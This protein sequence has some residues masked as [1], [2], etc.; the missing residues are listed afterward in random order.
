MTL[1]IPSSRVMEQLGAH[2]ACACKSGLLI[3]L[4][5]DL[6]AGKT[7]LA[8]GFIRALGYEGPVKSPTYTLVEPYTLARLPV[9]HFDFFRLSSSEELEYLGF[10]D[11]LNDRS[12]CLI[13]WPERVKDSLP[14][15]DIRVEIRVQGLE[16]SVDLVPLSDAGHELLYYFSEDRIDA[17]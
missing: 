10:R 11:Y 17:K 9:Y 12:I 8:R 5:G 15:A 14:S 6:G 1:Q 16:R 13:E 2:W 3:L 7:T 4:Q